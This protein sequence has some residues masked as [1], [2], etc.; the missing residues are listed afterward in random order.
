MAKTSERI[1]GY[2]REIWVAPGPQFADAAYRG[3]LL[4]SR[5]RIA[6]ILLVIWIPLWTY[7]R[8]PVLQHRLGLAAGILALLEAVLVLLLVRRRLFVQGMGFV[9]ILLDISLISG[10][11]GFFLLFAMPSIAV[12][13]R[14]VYPLYF[15]A[16]MASSLRYDARIGIVAGAAAA[17][18]Y[19]AI[20]LWAARSWPP[21]PADD[22]S[23]SYGTLDWSDQVGRILLLGI[24]GVLSARFVVR[25]R[26]L[27]LLSTRDLLTGVANRGFF[28][29]RLSEEGERAARLGRPVAVAM[30]DLD[31]FKDFNDAFGHSTGDDLLRL[32]AR[33]LR[34]F[35]RAIDVVA[36]YGGEEFAVIL[37]DG[38]AE[39]ATVRLEEL[40]RKVSELAI[41]VPNGPPAGV[42]V[43]IGVAAW[44]GDGETIEGALAAADRRLYDAKRKG[45]NRVIGPTTRPTSP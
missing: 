9:S 2:W 39:E 12:N 21:N 20:V 31:H 15:F 43:S 7:L 6:I 38:G 14:I 42:T 32:L 5:M 25:S 11:L 28:D 17:L 4:A 41:P 1:A 30:L 24:A 45:R 13:S 22:P 36:R 34:D 16:I 3:E 40:R 37:P 23:A 8:R 19:T 26:Q 27:L 29:L 18:Q 10:V 44:P 33:Q 35:F